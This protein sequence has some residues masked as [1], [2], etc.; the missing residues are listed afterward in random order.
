MISKH[1]TCFL[2]S[3][4]AGDASGDLI[5]AD[6]ANHVSS[7]ADYEDEGGEAEEGEKL[8][9]GD[10]DAG[11]SEPA[12]G[13][14]PTLSPEVNYDEI[15]GM[16][17]SAVWAIV[18]EKGDE[19]KEF[20]AY[21]KTRWADYNKEGATIKSDWAAVAS[22]FDGL[23]AASRADKKEVDAIAARIAAQKKEIKKLKDTVYKKR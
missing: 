17:K 9:F 1:L 13:S 14:A 16:K 6:V 18:E 21:I 5:Q 12:Q 20:E 2:M 3:L 7:E 15:R 4:M 23:K 11:P 10:E 19:L 8:A 22:K